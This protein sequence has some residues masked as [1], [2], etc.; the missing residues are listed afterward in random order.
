M[1]VPAPSFRLDDRAGWR[2]ALLERVFAGKE[3]RLAKLPGTTQ[4]LGSPSGNFGGLTTP[5]TVAVGYGGEIFLLDSASGE[6][7]L[8]DP[9]SE[10]FVP[11]PCMP[12][13]VEGREPAGLLVDP[14]GD[15]LVLDVRNRRIE[16]WSS[17]DWRLRGHVGPFAWH[18]EKLVPIRPKPALDP[19][20]GV[21]TGALLF[22]MDA[23]TPAGLALLPGGKL[24]VSD[25]DQGLI[26]LFDR[27]FRHVASLDGAAPGQLPLTKPTAMTAD[28]DGRLYVVEGGNAAVAVIDAEG[29]IVERV[30]TADA[31]AGRF[32]KPTLA[33]DP[34]GTI[35]I[36][37]RVSGDTCRVRRSCAGACLPAERV[38][39]T[40]AA[41]SLLAF[42]ASGNAIFGDA[43]SPCL[44]RSDGT[45]YE[46]AGLFTSGTLDSGL[47][48]CVWDTVELDA[49]VPFGT[50]L[51]VLT[52]TSHFDMSPAEIDA[53]TPD[54]WTE[55]PVM[56]H[57]EGGFECAIRSRPGRFL[58]LRLVFEGDG[59][60]TP[61]VHS[62][63]IRWPRKTSARYLPAAFSEEPVSADFLARF[64]EIFDRAR[65]DVLEPLE[66]LPAYFDPLA[67]PAAERGVSGADFLD[68][69]ASWV[70]LSL[71]R[72]WPA[73]RRRALVAEAPSLF[74]MRGTVKGLKRHVALYTGTEP[75]VVEHFRLRRWL[76]LDEGTLDDKAAL[77]GPEIVRRL[78]LDAYSEVG[79]FQLVD[80]GDPLTDPFDTFAHRATLYVPIGEAF[81]DADQAAL[82]AIVELAKPAHVE[83]DVRLMRPRFVIGC[84]LVLGVNTVIG[85]DTK[86][87]RTEEAVLGEEILLD[88][89]PRPFAL[90]AGLRIGRDTV[91]E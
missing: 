43:R 25:R 5:V 73:E 31:I 77:W 1:T 82:E 55:T 47:S 21:P 32:D 81:R 8:Y 6:I 14:R 69:L 85:R 27:R 79:K 44:M 53:L 66:T 33:I 19:L 50:R 24:A 34:D 12:A 58:W 86:P 89:P 22:S 7:R 15:L 64:L 46:L 29:R 87:A 52:S 17:A 68:W 16:S 61:E 51:T 78:Q 48:S 35:W 26:H 90:G 41:C 10:T 83:I 38:R 39:P 75:L 54:Q 36:S 56:G 9:C 72:N 91:L 62:A 80:G 71:D 30:S 20:T 3:L 65:A 4:P 45:R 18:G 42:D 70:G 13:N 40:P 88:R 57:R 74:R 49:E 67:T 76:S 84:D 37:D 60:A 23:W 63:V 28:R 2:A 11:V 59:A